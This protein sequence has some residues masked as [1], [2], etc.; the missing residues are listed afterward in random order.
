MKHTDFTINALVSNHHQS[1]SSQRVNNN[2]NNN[3]DDS[4][5][6]SGGIS[7]PEVGNM[8]SNHQ[9]SQANH[10]QQQQF[11][12]LNQLQLNQDG[13]MNRL[14]R[15]PPFNGGHQQVSGSLSS[16]MPIPT[17]GASSTLNNQLELGPLNPVAASLI[18]RA[19]WVAA[20]S[21]AAQS[22]MSQQH[23]QQLHHRSH[24]Q[25][26]SYLGPLFN[27]SNFSAAGNTGPTGSGIGIDPSLQ[28]LLSMQSSPSS[29]IAM[30][31][32]VPG[33]IN[34][35]PTPMGINPPVQQQFC[36]LQN[37]DE[38]NAFTLA[39]KRQSS[40]S[41]PPPQPKDCGD[42]QEIDLTIS[43]SPPPP[44]S[45]FLNINKF[46]LQRGT[47][48]TRKSS[49]TKRLKLDTNRFNNHN[50]G[51]LIP[52][53]GFNLTD[54]HRHDHLPPINN[55]ADSI[56]LGDNPSCNNNTNGNNTTGSGHDEQLTGV[57]QEGDDEEN[58]QDDNDDEED[59]DDEDEDD[60]DERRRR[61]RKTK[62]PR[63][64]SC[65]RD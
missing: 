23:N 25:N 56:V 13:H 59:V 30:S 10:Q 28:Q 55:T 45:S 47:T 48:K 44:T 22:I 46:E 49:T 29:A 8:F 11:N 51:N 34:F 24:V 65:D 61:A 35:N 53:S 7:K 2:S 16:S 57:N 20:A 27:G 63:A 40:C 12:G 32:H 64:V 33:L 37:H 6:R 58:R 62:I 31:S 50:I 15:Q 14:A 54:D 3:R 4:I 9:V 19:D 43:D 5:H 1:K 36:A 60:D 38:Q 41:P 52:N 42:D 39:N 17:P 21:A 18:S 26:Q